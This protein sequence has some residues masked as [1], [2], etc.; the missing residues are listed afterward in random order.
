MEYYHLKYKTKRYLWFCEG[1][2]DSSSCEPGHKPEFL[3]FVV[4]GFSK[5]KSPPPFVCSLFFNAQISNWEGV[6]QLEKD[7]VVHESSQDYQWRFLRLQPI[8]F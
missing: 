3:S 5:T 1:A 2:I 6:G 8:F 4:L 7:V